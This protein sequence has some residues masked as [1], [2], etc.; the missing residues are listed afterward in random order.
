MVFIPKDENNLVS[1]FRINENLKELM[2]H[3]LTKNIFTYSLMQQSVK[4]ELRRAWL[5]GFSVCKIGYLSRGKENKE[6]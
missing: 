6:E 3:T 1:D 4:D 5:V 2:E